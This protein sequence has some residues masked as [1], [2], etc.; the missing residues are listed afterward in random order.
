MKLSGTINGNCNHVKHKLKDRCVGVDRLEMRKYYAFNDD[1]YVGIKGKQMYEKH[2]KSAQ[3]ANKT[4]SKVKYA[5]PS[6]KNRPDVVIRSRK[7]AYNMAGESK[8]DLIKM[9]NLHPTDTIGNLYKA[10]QQCKDEDVEMHRLLVEQHDLS[11]T[12]LVGDDHYLGCL[13][14]HHYDD[15]RG[16]R[17]STPLTMQ[18]FTVRDVQIIVFS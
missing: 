4:S 16:N 14:V 9:Y 8:L 12:H 1:V 11:N 7:V 13:R 2:K 5:K 6:E 10:A 17:G 18:L 15:T 3:K